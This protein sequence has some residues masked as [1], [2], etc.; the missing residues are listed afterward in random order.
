[1]PP[2]TPETERRSGDSC[3]AIC[4]LHR[5][6]VI[7]GSEFQVNL[8][9]IGSRR[10]IY[11][12]AKCCDIARQC[13]ESDRKPAD[14]FAPKQCPECG[15]PVIG[16]LTKEFCSRK[17]CNSHLS[18]IET[19]KVCAICNR[20]FLADGYVHTCSDACS[21]KLARLRYLCAKFRR[22]F[23]RVA[24][25][26]RCDSL[27]LKEGPAQKLCQP[28]ITATAALRRYQTDLR[29]GRNALP[30]SDRCRQCNGKLDRPGKFC[31]LCITERT[32][33]SS[34]RCAARRRVSRFKY[35]Q[36]IF[37]VRN[38]FTL[39]ELTK[40]ITNQSYANTTKQ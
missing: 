3:P 15:K 25:C 34:R 16:K 19:V 21:K 32:L 24:K 28:C 37:A 10:R 8:K 7:C 1:M 6:C 36:S 39:A 27:F 23:V 20:E 38:Y 2:A 26:P 4:S 13:R 17:C 40:T 18:H 14:Y 29:R 35:E 12:S 5:Q 22:G 33:G 31:S 11:C 30:P 9:Y